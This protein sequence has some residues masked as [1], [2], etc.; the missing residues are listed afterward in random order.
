MKSLTIPT[1]RERYSLG[2]YVSSVLILKFEFNSN[3][4]GLFWLPFARWAEILEM[5]RGR[6]SYLKKH[7]QESRD[8]SVNRLVSR[9]KTIQFWSWLLEQPVNLLK[10]R[11]EASK[12]RTFLTHIL[13]LLTTSILDRQCFH[14]F[15][16]GELR[17]AKWRVFRKVCRAEHPIWSQLKWDLFYQTICSSVRTI[18]AKWH[19]VSPLS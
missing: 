4:S 3:D 8:S 13:T 15:V 11:E 17:P 19:L 1:R 6:Q 9:S 14:T 10:S 5:K 16:Y 2:T 7:L 12:W 18:S